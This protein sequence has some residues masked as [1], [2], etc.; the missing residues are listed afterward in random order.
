VLQYSAGNLGMCGM[1]FMPCIM[2][3]LPAVFLA[4]VGH[5]DLHDVCAVMADCHVFEQHRVSWFIC[6]FV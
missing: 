3:A 1:Y 4:C 6:S 2:D 5:A